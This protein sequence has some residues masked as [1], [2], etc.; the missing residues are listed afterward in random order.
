MSDLIVNYY[1]NLFKTQHG[2]FNVITNIVEKRVF[3]EI[4]EDL[5]R[6]STVEKIKLV[7]F[8]MHP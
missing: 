6:P 2:T 8:S 7:V 4:N 1:T 5:K 3:K